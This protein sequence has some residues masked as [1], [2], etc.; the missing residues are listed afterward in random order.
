MMSDERIDAI[1]GLNAYFKMFVNP[2]WLQLTEHEI[3][4]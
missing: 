1:C 2:S 4:V 3:T